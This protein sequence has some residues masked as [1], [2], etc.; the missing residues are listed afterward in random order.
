MIDVFSLFG[1]E[2]RLVDQIYILATVI[3]GIVYCIYLCMLM[4]WLQNKEGQKDGC[5]L[6][7]TLGEERGVQGG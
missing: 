6:Y 2:N 5:R 4:K 3:V 7:H 1:A